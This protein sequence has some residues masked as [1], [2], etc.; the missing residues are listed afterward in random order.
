MRLLLR[1][2]P[3]SSFTRNFS[4]PSPHLSPRLTCSFTARKLKLHKSRSSPLHLRTLSVGVRRSREHHVQ[5]TISLSAFAAGLIAAALGVL[6]WAQSSAPQNSQ[7]DNPTLPMPPSSDQPKPGWKGNLTPDQEAKLKDLWTHL[8]EITTPKPHNPVTPNGAAPA[9]SPNPH[10]PP[11]SGKKKKRF[12]L[13]S[14]S[15]SPKSTSASTSDHAASPTDADPAD[16]KYN[17]TREYRAALAEQT[18]EQLRANIRSFTKHDDPDALLLRFLRARKWNVQAALVMLISTARWRSAQVHLDDQLLPNGEAWFATQEAHGHG[19]SRQL[20]AD[21]MRQLRMGKS[22]VHGTD[23]AGQPVCYVRVRLHRGG[24]HSEESLEKLTVYV[25]E[26]TRLMLR[27]PVDTAVIVFDMTGFS[28]ANMDYSPVKFMIKVFEA[29]YPESLGAI[30][31]HRSPWLF[32][33]I[34]SV[35]KGWLDPVVAGKVHF[36]KDGHELAEYIEPSMVPKECGGEED[37]EYSYVEPGKD[38]NMRMLDGQ[39]NGERERIEKERTSLFE[40]FD[41]ETARWTRREG[42]EECV[43][44]REDLIQELGVNYWKL[45]PFVRARSLYDRIGLIG[46][47]G[48]VDFSADAR[49]KSKDSDDVD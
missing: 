38:E 2:A 10:D 25:I 37:W 13:F 49:N 22:V 45:D 17:Q 6:A 44:R 18:P 21:F 23:R 1:T 24:E 8:L 42:G 5:S 3:P 33:S 14:S 34:W 9:P 48:K 7:S 36:T 16:D 46:K 35:I 31:V 43:K 20:G 28:M 15:S 47:D 12:T 30:C 29:N 32:H 39:V 40:E 19:G 4:L 26:T 41:K 11:D 27:A